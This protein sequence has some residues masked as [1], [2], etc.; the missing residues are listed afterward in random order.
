M[1]HLLRVVHK[2][3]TRPGSSRGSFG[4]FR[5][6]VL[7]LRV[8][9][10]SMLGCYFCH[11]CQV[12]KTRGLSNSVC[13]VMI[14]WVF[15]GR[16]RRWSSDPHGHGIVVFI[17]LP[18]LG[19][20][21]TGIRRVF[22]QR[23][24]S[25]RF[26]HALFQRPTF[27]SQ[28]PTEAHCFQFFNTFP[29]KYPQAIILALFQNKVSQAR[30]LLVL[31]WDVAIAM[32]LLVLRQLCHAFIKRQSD[33]MAGCRLPYESNKCKNSHSFGGQI[34]PSTLA[35]LS[36]FRSL[37]THP[38]CEFEPFISS[39]PHDRLSARNV[40]MAKFCF[41]K[42]QL[43]E[44]FNPQQIIKRVRAS[45]SLFHQDI[46]REFCFLASSSFLIIT[47]RSVTTVSICCSVGIFRVDSLNG[48]Q[49]GYLVVVQCLKISFG[50]LTTIP[51]KHL[52]P[53]L[54]FVSLLLGMI[55][56]LSAL[57]RLESFIGQLLLD[58]RQLLLEL[59]QLLLE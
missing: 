5:P 21:P 59:D 47:I 6:S 39:I 54:H 49:S 35:Q 8:G 52:D 30:A 4:G 3:V 51:C 31:L 9:W 25:L 46:M 22:F 7:V 15:I 33:L 37:S 34:G 17:S 48:H 58:P 26:A 43:L 42:F 55:S 14:I 12:V 36:V 40:T 2:T 53:F 18:C 27:V 29:G 45:S 28:T 24:Q 44:S 38:T 23:R 19:F 16:R 11:G 41:K 32:F 1:L 50:L 13:P 57:L 56:L 20:F 10:I